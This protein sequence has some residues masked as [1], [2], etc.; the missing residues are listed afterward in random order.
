MKSMG[1]GERE[2]GREKERKREE[3]EGREKGRERG[4]FYAIMAEHTLEQHWK[5]EDV[6]DV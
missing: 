1:G 6:V 3:G 5:E 2:G 4:G